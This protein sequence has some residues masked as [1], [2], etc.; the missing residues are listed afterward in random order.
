[1]NKTS[2]KSIFLSTPMSAFSEVEL[3]EFVSWCKVLEQGLSERLKKTIYCAALK[4]PS[5][6]VFGSEYESVINDFKAIDE[7][8]TFILIYPQ[9]LATSALIELGYAVAKKKPIL[10][11][12]KNIADLP[13]MARGLSEAS[14]STEVFICDSFSNQVLNRIIDFNKEKT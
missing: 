11:V 12:A 3:S 5:A 6:E 4:A 9:K 8:S 10:I 2:S 13:F 1:M 14:S 7:C